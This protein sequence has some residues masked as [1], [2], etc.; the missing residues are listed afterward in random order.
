MGRKPSAGS[1]SRTTTSMALARSE[2]KGGRDLPCRLALRIAQNECQPYVSA[3]RQ[4]LNHEWVEHFYAQPHRRRAR[5]VVG[6]AEIDECRTLGL[7]LVH[8]TT[9]LIRVSCA[10]PTSSPRPR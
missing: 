4:L 7:D 8:S 9:T 2:Q 3:V 6:P 5:H 1:S 10:V